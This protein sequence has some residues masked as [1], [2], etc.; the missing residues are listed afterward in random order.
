MGDFI[1]RRAMVDD[2]EAACAVMIRSIE[3]ICAPFYDHDYEILSEWLANKTPAN[4]RNWI[5][6]ERSFSVVAIDRKGSAVGFAMLS[7]SEI[8]LNYVIPE[9]LHQGIG[10][11][12]LK[13]LEQH[14]LACGVDHIAV[15]SSVPAKAFYERSGYVSSGPP[16]YVGRILGDFPLA[17]RIR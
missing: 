2:A 14:A 9:A 10:K 8:V 11:R 17:K 16:K 5:E 15:V 3:E 1:I 6:S 4:V 7:G 13:A 12:M